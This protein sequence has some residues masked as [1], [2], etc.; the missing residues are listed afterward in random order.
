MVISFLQN[1]LI[2]TCSFTVGSGTAKK[3][4]VPPLSTHSSADCEAEVAPVH[5]MTWSASLPL[6]VSLS[7]VGRFSLAFRVV[8]APNFFASSSL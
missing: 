5:T 6:F 2:G 8:V 1:W 3:R 7:F 4:I